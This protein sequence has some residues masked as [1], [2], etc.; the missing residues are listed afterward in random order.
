MAVNAN[1]EQTYKVKT[2]REDLQDALVSIV[3][4][5]TPF[6]S[7]AG[8]RDVE[9]TKYEWAE[10][11]LQEP[12]ANN[13]VVEGEPNP[14]ND[15]PNN[16]VRLENYTQIS[17]K[18]AE[19]SSTNEAV[20]GVG[21][22]HKMAKQIAMKLKEL[23]KDMEVMLLANVGANPGAENVARVTA[24][25][26]AFLRTNVDRGAGG[27]NAP[28]SGGTSGYPSGAATD[29][30]LR[31][32]TETMLQDMIGRCWE[33]GSEP[34]TVLC[35]GKVKT[36]ISRTFTGTAT[37][38]REQSEKTITSAI[39]VYVSDFGTVSI[40]PTRLGRVRDV[41]VLDPEYVKVAWLQ[42]TKQTPL[43]KTSPHTERRAISNEYG[44]Q[45]DA[46]KAH[47][48]IADIDPAL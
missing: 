25:L 37:K 27:A 22:A 46:E 35:G 1:V 10:I 38:Y 48:L 20:N 47:G 17:D 8:T 31:A 7:L 24:G 36:K 43:A 19:A 28:L 12:D 3:T 29:G 6:Q 4:T 32:L 45:V 41:L 34:S 9:N 26:P 16:A 21:G 33:Q 40:Q 18:I 39:D 2:L 14:A 42:K 30:T 13:R 15:A 23:K 44:L 11:G 5:E